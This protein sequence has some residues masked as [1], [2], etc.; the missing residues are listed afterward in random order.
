[1]K[2]TELICP[3]QQGNDNDKEGKSAQ[4]TKHANVGNILD[5]SFFLEIEARGKQHG[6]VKDSEDNLVVEFGLNYDKI[7]NCS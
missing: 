6:R 3:E 7:T 4:Y 2:D 5:E 1:M